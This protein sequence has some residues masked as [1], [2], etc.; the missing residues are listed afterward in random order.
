[1]L[2]HTGYP[3]I[4]A[5]EIQPVGQHRAAFFLGQSTSV[6]RF[7]TLVPKKT[8][9]I[10]ITLQSCEQRLGWEAFLLSWLHLKRY[11]DLKRTGS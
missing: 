5:D 11:C 10:L 2:T 8:C 7:K 9:G 4:L 1:V 3:A 6:L